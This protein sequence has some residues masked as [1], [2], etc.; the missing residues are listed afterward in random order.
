MLWSYPPGT[1]S[2]NLPLI[3]ESACWPW[4]L[5][6]V[7][8]PG[9]QFLT[10]VFQPCPPHLGYLTWAPASWTISGQKMDPWWLQKLY[11][12]Q[13]RKRINRCV[14]G[15]A[16]REMVDL[17]TLQ[18]R[19]KQKQQKLSFSVVPA[20]PWLM[21]SPPLTGGEACDHQFLSF[22]INSASSQNCCI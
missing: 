4:L 9:L 10:S 22:S 18:C 7:L 13:K 15:N 8:Q 16:E 3:L 21:N 14:E 5:A 12:I 6:P 2:T 17:G 1:L 11:R 20:L 19:N